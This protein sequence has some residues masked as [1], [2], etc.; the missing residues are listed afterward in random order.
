MWSQRF[1]VFLQPPSASC[2]VEV[3][4]CSKPTCHLHGSGVLIGEV[5]SKWKQ[6]AAV[7]CEGDWCKDCSVLMLRTCWLLV[8][9]QLWV[10]H[11]C[12]R[13]WM[14][15]RGVQVDSTGPAEYYFKFVCKMCGVYFLFFLQRKWSRVLQCFYCCIGCLLWELKDALGKERVQREADGA[16]WVLHCLGSFHCP[17]STESCMLSRCDLQSEEGALFNVINK[18]EQSLGK[19]I[20]EKLLQGEKIKCVCRSPAPPKLQRKIGAC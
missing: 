13:H 10:K 14:K 6:I 2:G 17:C 18:S 19:N 12:H 8:S 9:D 15:W 20:V 3:S 16:G 5:P 7:L 11:S 1:E 4:L